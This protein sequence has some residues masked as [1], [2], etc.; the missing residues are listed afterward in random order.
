MSWSVLASGVDDQDT[1]YTRMTGQRCPLETGQKTPIRP[2]SI[3][4][5]VTF[6]DIGLVEVV[7]EW[8][9]NTVQPQ[10][11]RSID[12]VVVVVVTRHHRPCK[13]EQLYSTAEWLPM[14][15]VLV[16]ERRQDSIGFLGLF[17]LR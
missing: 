3:L 1:L 7:N 4:S 17:C 15:P 11:D 8:R 9:H 2:A 14:S 13:Q 16:D 5:G 6:R 10:V 12:I